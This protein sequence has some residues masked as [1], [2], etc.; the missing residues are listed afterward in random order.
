MVHAVC[1]LLCIPCCCMCVNH[2]SEKN[3]ISK[4][5]EEYWLGAKL[6]NSDTVILAIFTYN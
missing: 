2:L 6:M 1:F 5:N 3:S 4:T